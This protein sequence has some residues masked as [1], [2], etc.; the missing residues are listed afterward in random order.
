MERSSRRLEDKA[1]EPLPALFSVSNDPAKAHSDPRSGA[2]RLSEQGR[3]VGMRPLGV[4]LPDGAPEWRRPTTRAPTLANWIVEPDNPL[5]AR[6]MVNRIW[7]YH[8]GRGIVATPN[9]F[10]RMG[11]RPTHPELLDYLANRFV[12][13]DGTGSRSI[14]EILLSKRIGR[15]PFAHRK[16]RRARRIPITSC[17]GIS[18]AAGWTP[19]RFAMRCWP[20]RAS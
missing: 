14:G 20:W 10:G 2:R 5:T 15:L 12:E 9:D 13:A 18:R 1:P 7:Q 19:K 16:G 6:V 8:F 11:A 17:C 4:L 3:A